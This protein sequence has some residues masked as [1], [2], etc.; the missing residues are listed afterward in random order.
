MLATQRHTGKNIKA[1]REILRVKQEVLADALGVSQQSIS[2]MEQR[3]TVEADLLQKIANILKVP[4]EA[5]ENF[6]ED[7][8]VS[9]IANT[10]NNTN[11]D[12]VNNGVQYNPM[13]N[14]Y[15]DKLIDLYE[16]ML[17][18]KDAAIEQLRQEKNK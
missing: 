17:K 4:V 18:E 12:S 16:R 5:I 6:R 1:I 8:A 10:Y 7:A 9:Y 3:E 14:Y 13:F 15:A 2:L 11:N